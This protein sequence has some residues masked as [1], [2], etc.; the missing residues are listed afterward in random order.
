MRW[1]E[2][3]I[4]L[5][6]MMVPFFAIKRYDLTSYLYWACLTALYL[7]YISARRWEVE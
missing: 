5:L 1:L 7:L 4:V 3:V 2:I 6:A